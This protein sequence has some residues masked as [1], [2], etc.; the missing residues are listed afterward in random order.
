MAAG[1]TC[2]W[3]GTHGPSDALSKQYARGDNGVAAPDVEPAAISIVHNGDSAGQPVE[4]ALRG[5]GLGIVPRG[6]AP[7]AEAQVSTE[8][9]G[10]EQDGSVPQG[11]VALPVADGPEAPTVN[12]LDKDLQGSLRRS[13][14]DFARLVGGTFTLYTHSADMTTDNYPAIRAFLVSHRAQEVLQS[15]GIKSNW[16]YGEETGSKSKS[17]YEAAADE[18]PKKQLQPEEVPQPVEAV[19]GPNTKRR[20]CDSTAGANVSPAVTDGRNGKGQLENGTA[21]TD[22]RVEVKIFDVAWRTENEV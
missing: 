15:L 9:V 12:T 6:D 2:R 19:A 8:G 21:H 20:K 22:N 16:R 18:A 14:Y 13:T 3:A 11:T 10:D 5:A 17:R 7:A 4:S 1:I